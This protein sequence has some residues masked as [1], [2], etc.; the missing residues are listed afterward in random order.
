MLWKGTVPI[1]IYKYASETDAHVIINIYIY[2]I[3][4]SI[5]IY[6]D[7]HLIEADPAC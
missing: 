1:T 6:N 4:I 3:L 5:T 7:I 2:I